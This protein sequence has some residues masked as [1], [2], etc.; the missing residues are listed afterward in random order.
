MS[1]CGRRRA[2]PVSELLLA[3]I[4]W[5][6]LGLEAAD[7]SR[8][9]SRG[10]SASTR[11]DA[12]RRPR[13][14]RVVAPRGSSGSACAA[15]R[16]VERGAREGRS[17]A[18]RG[19]R[20]PRAPRRAARAPPAAARARRRSP[21]RCHTEPMADA[22]AA[23]PRP[24]DR[25]RPRRDAARLR[26]PDRPPPRGRRRARRRPRT[27]AA[28]DARRAR[29]DVRQVRPA[30]LD[31]AR[32]RPAGHHRRAPQA[33]G[34]RLAV[35]D[36]RT[37]ERVV[38]DELGLSIE[39][40]FVDFDEQPIAAASI[41]QVHRATLPNDAEVVVKVQRPT[42]PRQI[43]SDLKLMALGRARGPRARA[44]A[45]LHRRRR[46]RRRVRALDPAGARL[47]AGG[48]QRGD[49]P[50]QLRA[51]TSASPCRASGGGTRPSR[52]LTLDRLERDARRA[53]STSA[54]GRT[55]SG[56]SSRTR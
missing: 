7:E 25:D 2:R 34:R 49:V 22:A 36:R 43:E 3:G 30:P 21:D 9:T 23:Q 32:R 33:P 48:A 40:A 35:P 46:A 51:A 16:L 8:T 38:Q 27:P 19:G 39:Q 10:G 13:H 20:R 12:R 4:G 54:A 14:R 44:A 15:T 11:R 42:A 41:G 1:A 47:P 17:R 26:L 37:C 55:R 53:T 24:G 5:A 50:P 31:A 52:L 29:A 56:A 18:P 45:R 6:S 28:R